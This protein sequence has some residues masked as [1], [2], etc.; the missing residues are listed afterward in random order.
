VSGRRTQV[1]GRRARSPE[2]SGPRARSPELR[3]QP[4]WRKRPTM[5]PAQFGCSARSTRPRGEPY[6]AFC[7]LKTGSPGE[8]SGS[9]G[10]RVGL[11]AVVWSTAVAIGSSADGDGVTGRRSD[12]L[13]ESDQVARGAPLAGG[14]SPPPAPG[15]AL[16]KARNRRQPPLL[17]GHKHAP[18]VFLPTAGRPYPGFGRS[19]VKG[20]IRGD[21]KRAT[22]RRHR[23]NEVTSARGRCLCTR[24]GR[25]RVG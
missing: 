11:P 1:S 22:A 6:C 2:L 15:C 20:G 13:G 7:E 23:S 17:R 4:A 16:Y 14:L 24:P 9:A 3:F 25:D 19:P 8:G 10:R 12:R 5:K 18:A 21:A